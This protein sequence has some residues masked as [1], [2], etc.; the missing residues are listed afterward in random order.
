MKYLCIFTC[1]YSSFENTSAHDIPDQPDGPFSLKF[2]CSPGFR[3]EAVMWQFAI[4]PLSIPRDTLL[5]AK[6]IYNRESFKKDPVPAVFIEATLLTLSY[7]NFSAEYF[8]LSIVLVVDYRVVHWCSSL[9]QFILQLHRNSRKKFGIRLK[10]W[11]VGIQDDLKA[12]V[13]FCIESHLTKLKNKISLLQ[14]N[15][16]LLDKFLITLGQ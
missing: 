7:I 1:T 6:K 11:E 13:H 14:A 10:Q 4:R 16:S 9:S 3:L 12:Q 15:V 8:R 2:C 5:A